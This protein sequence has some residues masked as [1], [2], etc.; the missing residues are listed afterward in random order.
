[1]VSTRAPTVSNRRPAPRQVVS[2][3]SAW[4]QIARSGRLSIMGQARYRG[5]VAPDTRRRSILLSSCRRS[6]RRDRGLHSRPGSA[7]LGTRFAGGALI[8]LSTTSRGPAHDQL[9]SADW[10]AVVLSSHPICNIPR[11]GRP[12]ADRESA[13]PPLLEPGIGLPGH[14]SC[15]RTDRAAPVPRQPTTNADGRQGARITTDDLSDFRGPGRT[16]R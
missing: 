13:P 5:D 6:V 12:T 4:A 11:N 14:R 2:A 10:G 3:P 1:M 8:A 16:D 9:S 15:R 7:F